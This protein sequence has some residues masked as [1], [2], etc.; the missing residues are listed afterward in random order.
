MVRGDEVLYGAMSQ[1]FS[2][3]P[4]HSRSW[5]E[6]AKGN[7]HAWPGCQVR[8]GRSS[9]GR[10]GEERAKVDLGVVSLPIVADFGAGRR[11]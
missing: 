11:P 6:N 1:V 3:S 10:V 8:C 9:V 7:C 5:S 2:S 4:R